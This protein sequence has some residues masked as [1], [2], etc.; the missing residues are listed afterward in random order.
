MDNRNI[1]FL[2]VSINQLTGMFLLL[3]Q[4]AAPSDTR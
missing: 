3:S 1:G 4:V 2:E